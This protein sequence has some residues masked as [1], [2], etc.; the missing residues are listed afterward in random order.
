MA[1]KVTKY[2]ILH[3]PTAELETKYNYR[4]HS[5]ET[6]LFKSE[7]AA[8]GYLMR[9]N[10]DHYQG[11]QR[12]LQILLLVSELSKIDSDIAYKMFL[13]IHKHIKPYNHVTVYG[14]LTNN[15]LNKIAFKTYCDMVAVMGLGSNSD[16]ICFEHYEV[17]KHKE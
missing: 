15:K 6:I 16:R 3:V 1:K 8:Y 10:M 5:Y 11:R 2:H 17:E 13:D 12:N 4:H 7:E 14:Y 9:S